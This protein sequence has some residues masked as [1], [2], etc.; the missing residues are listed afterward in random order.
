MGDAE[1]NNPGAEIAQ[2]FAESISEPTPETSA[3][4]TSEAAPESP[5]VTYTVQ[6]GDTLSKIAREYYGDSGQYQRI[7]E[8]NRDKLDDPDEISAGQEL[9]IPPA[10]S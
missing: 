2:A 4:A 6:S 1:N 5:Q 8:A 9:V 10:E 3:E 7:F